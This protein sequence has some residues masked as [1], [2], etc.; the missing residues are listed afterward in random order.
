[1]SDRT[2]DSINDIWGARTPHAAGA[3]WPARVD[4][5]LSE[6]PD[7]WVRGA[8][9]LCSNGCGLDIGVKAGRIVG[10]RGLASDVTNRGRLGPKGLHGWAANH[11]PD[12]LTTPLIREDG[13]FR[14]ASW[15]EAMDLI[16]RQSRQVIESHTAMGIGFYTSGQLFLEEYYTLSVIGKGGLGTPHMDGNT[17]LCTATAAAALK[18]SF[19]SDGQPGAYEDLDVT[20]TVLMVGHNMASQ[21]TVLWARI[22]DR[23]AGPNPPWIIVIDPR[24]TFTAEHATVHLTPR[25]GT[26]VAVMNG[27]LHLIIH[28]GAADQTFI[29]A[30]TVGYDDLQRT[31]ERYTP[32]YVQDLSGV[33]A[34]DLRRAA[35]ILAT[36]PTLVS[37]VLQGVYQ[38][39][40]ATAAA[41]QVNNVHLIRGLIGRPGSGILQMNGQPTAQNTRET[42]ADGDLPGFRNWGNAGH[43]EQ[44][45]TLWNVHRHTIP[46]WS[47][48]THAMQIW[49][50][51]EQGSI[52][53]LWIQA[54]N[55]AVSLPHLDRIRRIL[56]KDDLF[57]VVQDAFMTETAR[58]ADVVLPAAIWG[59][60]T[61]TFTNVSRTVHISCKAVEPPGEARSDLDIFLDYAR[62][63]DFR[64]QGGQPLIRWHDAESAFEAWKACTR[65][66]PCDYTGL[67]YEK[68][69]A[70]SGIP[71]PVNEQR[72]DG[73]VRLYTDFVFP[74]AADDAETYGHDLDTGAAHTEQEYRAN[75]PQGRAIIKAAEHRE[76][77]E[78]P[79]EEY[80]LWLTTG[81]QVYHFHTRTK[82]GR[83]QALQDAAPDA[84]VQISAEDA[85]QYGI[86][87]GDW[88]LIESR[89]GLVIERARIGDIKPGLV[90]IPWHYGYWDDPSRP[91]AANELTLTEWDPV[92]K[93][94]HYKYAAVRI[95]RYAARDALP[96][97]GLIGRA[98]KAV[99]GLL[100]QERSSAAQGSS[101]QE[102]QPKTTQ[103][104][105]G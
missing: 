46:H 79:D 93:Q 3:I 56:Q 31:V 10:V 2:R 24:R 39:M 61:G 67:T 80:P 17:R 53:M 57:V 48:P 23:L 59:E 15:D 25:V 20:D 88:I 100:G 28:A 85:Q 4:E 49:R 21:Q 96:A 73:T 72:P 29:D 26:N 11:S 41:V 27:L 87:Q 60:K 105:D 7:R 83:S 74:T 16:V 70:G 78:T 35:D 69:L 44:L 51:A 76:P 97:P 64:D 84:F 1:M 77:H 95:S 37:T 65:G 90:F 42:G 104:V 22:L 12:R 52:R 40:Q 99:Q 66:R 19:G 102:P 14:E 98:V 68:L 92:S 71:W 50:Y 91:R 55:P 75:D 86:E 8:C 43:I 101:A 18:V 81:R 36:T 45:A 5:H 34:A 47:P 6:T 103:R 89:R 9:V 32:E 33:P 54:T 82:T 58:Y 63:M 38:S 30:H 62:R 13:Q 94:P